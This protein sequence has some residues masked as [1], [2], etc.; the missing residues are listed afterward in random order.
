MRVCF[1]LF[2]FIL[3]VFRVEKIDIFRASKQP[4]YRLLELLGDGKP[5]G[6][7]FLPTPSMLLDHSVDEGAKF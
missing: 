5:D 3:S 2:L 6:G 1:F 7:G 4:L